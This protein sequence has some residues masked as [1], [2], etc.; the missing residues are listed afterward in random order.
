MCINFS[1]R[2]I[3]FAQRNLVITSAR[4]LGYEL[5]LMETLG[6]LRFESCPFNIEFDVGTGFASM[7]VERRKH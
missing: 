6:S 1:L 5:L 4:S 2:A 3:G 7:T